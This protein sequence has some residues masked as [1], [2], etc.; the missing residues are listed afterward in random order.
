MDGVP[1]LTQAAVAPGASFDYRFRPPDAGTFWYHALARRRHRPRPAWR[2]DRRRCAT[3]RGR[4]RACACAQHAG[5][6]GHRSGRDQRRRPSRFHRAR[7]RAAARPADQRHRRARR[8]AAVRRT[9][10][11]AGGDRRP[12]LG[13]VS[14]PRG[15]RRARA[16]QPD[17][18]RRG[19]IARGGTVAPIL[20]GDGD[21]VPVARL[22]YRAGGR[23]GRRCGAAGAA[24]A[25]AHS[26]AG[27]DRSA[28]RAAPGPRPR[29]AQV[30]Q[31]GGRAAVH[32]AAR[33]RGRA[34]ASQRWRGAAGRASARPFL[35]PSRPAGR[36][37]EALLARYHRDRRRHRADRLRGR[38]SRQMADRKPRARPPRPHRAK[39]I[40]W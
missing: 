1:G 12:A 33:A 5:G 35:P 24:A 17:R 31:S 15:P 18:P 29:Q 30:P 38:Q 7:G 4:S 19:C 40:S 14:D 39:R 2:A 13:T 20:A 27:A 11:L 34:D 37:L 10:R 36:W 8:R 16:G 6:S 22:V 28:D 23:A 32:R 3:G 26:V 21:G 9:C 25:A